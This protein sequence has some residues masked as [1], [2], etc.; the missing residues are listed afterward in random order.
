MKNDLR[1]CLN[2]KPRGG[3]CFVL[4]VHLQV[5]PVRLHVEHMGHSYLSEFT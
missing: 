5:L 2:R 3:N 1:F 4:K